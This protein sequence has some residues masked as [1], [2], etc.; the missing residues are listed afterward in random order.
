MSRVTAQVSVYP[1]RRASLG[2]AI[3]RVLRTLRRGDLAV[4]PGRMSTLVAGPPDE[5]FP[6]LQAAFEAASQ[7]GDVVMVLTV[8]NACPD[9]VPRAGGRGDPGESG[10]EE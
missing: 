3:E 2:P 1:L 10:G 4:E 7:G 5:L 8:S 6:A 9:S